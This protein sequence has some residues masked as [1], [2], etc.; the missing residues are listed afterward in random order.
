MS[1]RR[2]PASRSLEQE[3]S[4]RYGVLLT[5]R[6]LA[7]LLGRTPGGLRYSLA[8]PTDARTRALRESALRVGR[9]L[10]YPAAKVA[11][12]IERGRAT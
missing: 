7:D 8:S 10:Y 1:H 3:L 6:Q 4:A 2:Q 5:H 12:I 11:A 9:R